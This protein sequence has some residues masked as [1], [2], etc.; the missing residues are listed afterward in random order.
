MIS[1]H[2]A[3]YSVQLPLLIHGA[4]WA[5]Q[6]VQEVMQKR[7][8]ILATSCEG[9]SDLIDESSAFMIPV[10]DPERQ[11]LGL[12]KFIESP[13]ERSIRAQVAHEN[14]LREPDSSQ[15]ASDILEVHESLF[16]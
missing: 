12:M 15:M 5:N 6:Y 8:P 2:N 3:L 4:H 1:D 11:Y 7:I 16:G 9:H 14:I 13:Q 10:D